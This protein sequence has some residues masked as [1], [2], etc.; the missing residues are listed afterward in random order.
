MYGRKAM[1][2]GYALSCTETMAE[3]KYE[4][5]Y[6]AMPTDPTKEYDWNSE[7]TMRFRRNGHAFTMEMQLP[8]GTTTSSEWTKAK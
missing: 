3:F 7:G 6:L 5:D 2:T 4:V 8:D 1:F